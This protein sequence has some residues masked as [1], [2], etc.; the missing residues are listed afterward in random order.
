MLR[1]DICRYG[2]GPTGVRLQ[3]GRI[4][5]TRSVLRRLV[6]EF[7]ALPG[8][9]AGTYACPL[10]NG[11]AARVVFYNATTVLPISISLSGCRF[12][13]SRVGS[14]VASSGLATD[15]SELTKATR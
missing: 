2:T 8:Y 4:E 11:D 15:L 14:G 5:T 1:A 6:R 10:D 13:T 7:N 3:S 9:P 12:A